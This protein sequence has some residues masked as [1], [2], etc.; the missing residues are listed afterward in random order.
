MAER[1]Q[2]LKSHARWLPPFHFFVIPV[3]LL[4]FLNEARHLMPG[5][6]F[7]KGIS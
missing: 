4:N 5:L 6:F 3:L 2:S 7:C 1:V